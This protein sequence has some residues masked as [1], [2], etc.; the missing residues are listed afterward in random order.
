M[1]K[2][3][4]VVIGAGPGGYT[5]AIRA[6]KAGKKVAIIDKSGDIGGAC[7]YRGCIPAKTYLRAAEV[8]DSY[9]NME[10]FGI[11]TSKDPLL[12]YGD[13]K[14]YADSVIAK[15]SGGLNMLM[16]KNNIDVFKGFGKLDG[17]GKIQVLSEDDDRTLYSENIILATG[18]RPRELN[19]FQFD[20]QVVLSS[21]DCMGL[22]ELPPDIAIL[23]AGAVGVEVAS[24]MSRFNVPVTLIEGG[25]HILP[26]EEL[27]VSEVVQEKLERNGVA[28][29]L[30]CKVKGLVNDGP[31]MRL[32]LNGN[33]SH[34][35]ELDASTLLVAV[36]R[37]PNTSGLGLDSIGIEAMDGFIP[38]DGS[39]RTSHPGVW[40]IGDIV[41]TAQLAHVASA[42]AH[43]AAVDTLGEKT[44]PLDYNLVPEVTYCDPEVA[45]V[46]L[47]EDQAKEAGYNVRVKK[48]PLQAIGRAVLHGNTDGF[49]K[50]IVDE[51]YGEVLGVH[52]VG[53]RAGDL[54]SEATLAMR[55]EATAEEIANTIHPHP[56]FSEQFSEVAHALN[57]SP[58]HI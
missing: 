25:D 36:G 54:I 9:R 3:D 20:R 37:A 5:A 14:N 30:G 32:I 38:V 8:F 12:H 10:K 23:G 29:K 42:E 11:K 6:S 40:A 26:R 53:P 43:V 34:E 24:Y 22:D 58:I 27:E 49:I 1:D 55:L 28:I 13:L 41:K 47:T 44:E 35:E 31:D 48:V 39:M 50:M 56:T 16:K 46:G 15:L 4:L 2:Y 19:G 33:G 18:S 57:G 17:H 52:I 51:K 7:L 45:K 21:D